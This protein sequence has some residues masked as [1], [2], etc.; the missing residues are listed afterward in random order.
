MK[1]FILF[2]VEGEND[3]KELEA[4]LHAKCFEPFK[5]R[6]VPEIKVIGTDVTSEKKSSP[7]NIKNVVTK[8]V[9]EWRNGGIPFHD[10][11]TYEVKEI[12]HIVDIDGAFVAPARVVYTD[13][14]KLFYTDDVIQCANPNTI[15][16]RNNR[17]SN[18]LKILCAASQID[19]IPY[20][21]YYVSCNMD[22]VLFGERNPSSQ[23][24]RLKAND[25][26]MMCAKDPEYLLK[27]IFCEDIASNTMYEESWKQIGEGTNSLLRKTNFNL[28]FGDNAKNPK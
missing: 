15:I 26:R 21:I 3:R 16:E 25:F 18:C 10:I 19:N 7:K 20:S 11:K 12:V 5:D 28:F 4:I 6:Y 1:K 2:L 24:K 8:A 23:D 17:K 14:G 13:T 27:T 9:Q 22:H